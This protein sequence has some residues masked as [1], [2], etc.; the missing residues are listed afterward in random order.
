MLFTLRDAK[1][2]TELSVEIALLYGLLTGEG[3][4][5][6]FREPWQSIAIFPGKQKWK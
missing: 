5:D 1:G 2:A 3:V 6:A 4:P